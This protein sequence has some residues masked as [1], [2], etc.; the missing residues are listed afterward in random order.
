M[1]NKTEIEGMVKWAPKFFEPK[2]EGQKIISSFAIEWERPKSG[3]KKSVFH[4]KAFGDLAE[5]LRDENLDEGDTVT[6][7]GSLNESKWKDKKTDEWRNQIEVWAN[8]VEI[9]ERAGGPEPDTSDFVPVGGVE[10]EEDIPF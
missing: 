3:G 2:E 10:A 4:V 9:G 5:K 1:T 8:K 6:I 7:A